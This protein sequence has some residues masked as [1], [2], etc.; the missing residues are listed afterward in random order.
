MSTQWKRQ[1]TL[2]YYGN[3]LDLIECVEPCW[4]WLL[5]APLCLHCAGGCSDSLCV[6]LMAVILLCLLGGTI[7]MKFSVY[8]KMDT[9]NSQLSFNSVIISQSKAITGRLTSGR[10]GVLVLGCAVVEG[11]WGLG[12]RES[13]SVHCH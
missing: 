6:I 1:I 9:H 11:P 10:M 13:R 8:W 7:P 2:Q 3:D 4:E 5:S 12:V